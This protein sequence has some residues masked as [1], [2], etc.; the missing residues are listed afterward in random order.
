MVTGEGAGIVILERPDHAR[1]RRTPI[2]ALIIG[3]GATSVCTDVADV[4]GGEVGFGQCGAAL[5]QSPTISPREP[6]STASSAAPFRS[7]APNRSPDTPWAPPAPSKP[8]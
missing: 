8:P 1:A 5:P 4:A 3:F 6:C 7:A 2:K